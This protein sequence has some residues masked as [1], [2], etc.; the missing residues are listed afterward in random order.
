[1]AGVLHL[2]N[3]TK[4]PGLCNSDNQCLSQVYNYRFVAHESHFCG[5]Q[6]DS[7][8]LRRPCHHE[9]TPG[10]WGDP[11]AVGCPLPVSVWWSYSIS[12]KCSV[13]TKPKYANPAAGRWCG[14]LYCQPPKKGLG[15]IQWWKGLRCH[16]SWPWSW[17]LDK[18]LKTD[19]IFFP[20]GMCGHWAEMSM[21]TFFILSA[22]SKVKENLWWLSWLWTAER[23]HI[24]V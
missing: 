22:A 12:F 14:C 6:G 16:G 19:T 21:R 10:L 2:W 7:R 5:W 15:F 13:Q 24:C 18:E 23:F 17:A 1:M 8:A 20:Q 9:G 3:T 11:S 4:H